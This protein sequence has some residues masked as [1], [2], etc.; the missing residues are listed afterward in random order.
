MRGDNIYLVSIISEI[1]RYCYNRLGLEKDVRMVAAGGVRAQMAALRYRGEI[2]AILNVRDFLPKE[3]TDL[4]FFAHRKFLKKKPD[5]VKRSLG[6]LLKGADFALKNPDWTISQLKSSFGYSDSAARGM[7]KVL[8]YSKDGKL[9]PK[10]LANVR[11]VAVDYGLISQ[12]EAVPLDKLYT[13]QIAG[14]K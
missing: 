2:R 14:T 5:V 6:G 12:K 4:I 11:K 7:F 13:T 9:D 8:R 1:A 10:A 3:W